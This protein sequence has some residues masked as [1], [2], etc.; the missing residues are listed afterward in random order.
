VSIAQAL[1][2]AAAI[3]AA[4]AQGRSALVAYL[5]V[6]FPDVA[7][8]VAAARAAVEAGADVLELGMPY[9]DP[10]MD[11]PVIQHAVDTALKAGT[12]TRDL[13]AAVDQV[14]SAGAT[15]LVMTYWNPVDRY[16]VER[17]AKDLAS[18][19]GAGLITPDLIPD[20]AQDWLAASDAHGLE[21][22]FLV[23]PSSTPQRLAATAAACRGWVYAASTMGVT[24]ERAKV[25]GGAEA[26]VARARAAGAE[27]VC[28]GLGVSTRAQA[29]EVAGFADGVIVGSAF[30]RALTDAGSSAAGVDAVRRLAG[31]LSAGVREG[32]TA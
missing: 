20:E 29:A 17:F 27:R 15:A 8:S 12:R 18:A 23:A 21:R 2:S 30:V 7:T 3:D 9:S 24:G 16:G 14:A 25:G 1:S 22:I 13:L 32:R 5:P 4:I 6:G 31:E 26:L 28:V 19:G 10:L 11:G